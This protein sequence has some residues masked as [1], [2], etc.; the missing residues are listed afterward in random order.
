M[1]DKIKDIFILSILPDKV[2]YAQM[3]LPTRCF[4]DWPERG[5]M[6]RTIR[7]I[8]IST[9]PRSGTVFTFDFIAALFKFAKLE[10]KFTGSFWPAP[11]EWDP[12]KFDET[13]LQLDNQQV[14]CAH[15]HLTKQ[16]RDLLDND[17]VLGLHLYRD[18]RDMAVSAMLYIKHAL[19]PHFL[20]PLFSRLT[21]AE[22]LALM[23]A[24]GIVPIQ[25]LP[26]KPLSDKIPYVIYEGLKYYCDTSYPWLLHPKVA[27]LR[28]EDFTTNPIQAL[29]LALSQVDVSV[30]EADIA[31]ISKEMNF[32][33]ASGGRQVG[34]E[35]KGSHFR[36]GMIGNHKNYFSD[37]HRALCKLCVGTD[38]IQLGYEKDLDW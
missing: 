28:F 27:K 6:G 11:P 20:H 2:V 24:G 22:A 12:Y 4:L 37:M 31:L 38:L 33:S 1:C 13:Y 5:I 9:M 15:Y 30:P 17:E 10:P 7:K 34:S 16:I 32:S 18:P 14:I 29:A 36:K 3:R 23:I 35:D 19:T 25:D 8:L 21:E 26:Y